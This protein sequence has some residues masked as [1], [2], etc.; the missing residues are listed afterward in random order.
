MAEET[1]KQENVDKEE[2]GNG[3][4]PM[5]V[6]GVGIVALLGAVGFIAYKAITGAK[7]DIVDK[8]E[9]LNALQNNEETEAAEGSEEDNTEE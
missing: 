8:A 1:I 9:M 5:P 3:F 7:A 6:I 4:N 2:K